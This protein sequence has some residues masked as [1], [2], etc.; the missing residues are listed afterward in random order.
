MTAASSATLSEALGRQDG[1]RLWVKKTEMNL[2]EADGI[3]FLLLQ[4]SVC[5]CFAYW[6]IIGSICYVLEMLPGSSDFFLTMDVFQ[7]CWHF[8]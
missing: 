2:W 5:E 4:L 1:S 6:I 3:F 7:T 8:Q